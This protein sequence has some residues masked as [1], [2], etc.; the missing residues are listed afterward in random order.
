MLIYDI[1]MMNCDVICLIPSARMRNTVNMSKRKK[2]ISAKTGRPCV[3][4]I[5]CYR[6]QKTLDGIARFAHE[7]NWILDTQYFH[8]AQIP[9][10]WHGDGALVMLSSRDDHREIREFVEQHAHIP[11][12]D[13]ASTAKRITLPRVLQD[14][15]QIGRIGAEHLISRGCQNLGFLW[16]SHNSFHDERCSGFKQAAAERN[17][18]VV[19]IHA[20][21]TYVTSDQD[22]IW[23]TKYLEHVERPFG[24]MAAADYLAPWVL[25]ACEQANLSIPADI[26]LLGVDNSLEICELSSI[27]ISSIDNNTEQQGYEAAKLLHKLMQGEPPPAEPVLVPPGALHVRASSDIM[28]T[29][30]PHVATALLYISD[31]YQENSLT[32][33]Q[34][35]AQTAISQ[36]RLH[37]AFLKYVGRSMY[38]EITHRRLQQALKMMQSTNIT[39][40][41]VAEACGF[42]SAEVM[43]RL[44]S[45]TFG[46]AP[47]YFRRPK[48]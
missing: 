2:D 17:H 8:T 45:R 33:K 22:A 18:E 30:H 6:D 10:R 4:F 48:L 40:W 43:S 9:K 20:P 12:V 5:P 16:Q 37:D 15:I 47:S 13:L 7:A 28:A 24:I 39:I 27:A 21:G 11:T 36:R 25:Q 32:Q 19:R 46:H 34:V 29:R 42:K 23:L 14:N 41:D 1:N 31:H 35:A 44:F 26:A 38:Q 3:I